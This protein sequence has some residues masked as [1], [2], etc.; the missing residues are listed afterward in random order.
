[1]LSVENYFY[2]ASP[3][4]KFV[5]LC[6]YILSLLAFRNEAEVRFIDAGLARKLDSLHGLCGLLV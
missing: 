4:Q 1:M 5:S 2:I 3:D 6:L